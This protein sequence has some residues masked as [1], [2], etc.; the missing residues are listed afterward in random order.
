MEILKTTQD[1]CS[2]IMGLPL[3]DAIVAIELARVEDPLDRTDSLEWRILGQDDEEFP[4]SNDYKPWRVNLWIRR[5][6][7]ERASAG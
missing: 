2:Y 6:I 7:V 1:T 3:A 5:G 4:K